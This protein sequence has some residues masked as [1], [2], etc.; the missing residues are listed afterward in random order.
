MPR[1]KKPKHELDVFERAAADHFRPSY[2]RD[3]GR[4]LYGE[5]DVQV[6][7]PVPAI[8]ANGNLVAEGWEVDIVPNPHLV[9]W[10]DAFLAFD[11]RE[12]PDKAPM[13]A[14]LLDSKLEP[15]PIVSEWL[16]N[17][18]TRHILKKKKGLS[19]ATIYERKVLALVKAFDEL[20][21]T[22]SKLLDLMSQRTQLA[23]MIDRF[24]FINPAHRP[25]VPAYDLSDAEVALH[26]ADEMVRYLRST[27]LPLDEAIS[28]AA[29]KHDVN[30]ETLRNHHNGQ[31]GAT[32]RTRARN[33]RP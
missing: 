20:P 31:H 23:S 25:R 14:K 3:A 28:A 33:T 22:R 30:P 16:A 29:T 1:R 13:L 26:L 27:G 7:I 4:I 6:S 5:H 8:D 2:N 15:M 12:H 11:D 17:L 9:R 21:E 10:L 32:R 24:D 18:L 19:A